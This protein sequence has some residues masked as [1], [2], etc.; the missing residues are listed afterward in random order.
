MVLG[1]V[2]RSTKILAGELPVI[3]TGWSG[4]KCY[5]VPSLYIRYVKSM[6]SVIQIVLVR[7]GSLLPD[8]AVF[9]VSFETTNDLE[10]TG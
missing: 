3:S 10:Q 5:L 7:F 8:F 2:L 6:H 1:S 4:T 9:P